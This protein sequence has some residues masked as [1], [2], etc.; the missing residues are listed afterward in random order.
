MVSTETCEVRRRPPQEVQFCA[1]KPK[2]SFSIIEARGVKKHVATK[3]PAAQ[4][5]LFAVHRGSPRPL[6]GPWKHSE[7]LS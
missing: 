5:G 4:A 2:S 6:D 3:K 1:A 7:A